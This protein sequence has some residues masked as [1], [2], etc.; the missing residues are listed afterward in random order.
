VEEQQKNSKGWRGKNAWNTGLLRE[1]ENGCADLDDW[2]RAEE[3][4]PASGNNRL[5]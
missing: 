4:N 2:G 3:D 1:E 5:G